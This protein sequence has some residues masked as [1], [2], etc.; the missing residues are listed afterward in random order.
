MREVHG[1][2]TRIPESYVNLTEGVS[3][4]TLNPSVY[5]E[6][7]GF[8]MKMK[9]I[10]AVVLSIL[11]VLG[12][13][14][15][16]GGVQAAGN[17]VTVKASQIKSCK[18]YKTVKNSNPRLEIN[19]DV[20]LI[21]DM[22]ADLTLSKIGK[23]N[24]TVSANISVT[25]K[26]SK[27]L[28]V[29]SIGLES[30]KKYGGYG[31][32]NLESGSNVYA[33]TSAP[34]GRIGADEINIKSGANFT[35]S[36]TYDGSYPDTEPYPIECNSF[37]SSGNL[38]LKVLRANYCIGANEIVI[39]GGTVTSEVYGSTFSSNKITINSGY[40]DLKDTGSSTYARS[41]I[42]ASD[43][44]LGSSLYIKEPEGAIWKA[45][46]YR[47]GVH[48]K[49]GNIA[50]H[51]I[52][53]K[54]PAGYDNG[55]SSG[56]GS[57]TGSNGG[58][59]NEWVNG[60]WYNA[61]GSQT[62]KGTLKWKSDATGWWVED[63]DGWYPTNAWQK[64]DGIWYFFK[65]D[66][67]MAAN[68]YYNGYW[69]NADGSWAEQYFLTWKQNATGWWVEDISG[70]WPSN[71]WLKI[72]GYWYYFDASGYMVTNQYVDGWWIGADGICY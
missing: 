23:K 58:Y 34:G 63:T 44:V 24:W 8:A 50:Y 10:I 16:K 19:E 55:G 20:N 1:K 60:K 68:E 22:D 28:T 29:D 17:T 4:A 72:D 14:S 64:I 41:P 56:N 36:N 6:K 31:V 69:F 40:L 49:N 66:G 33:G 38:N 52:I 62:Y 7:E 12:T 61:D 18:Y 13:I 32:L 27:K 47:L 43:L 21:I 25:I 3:S 42:N 51:V 26:G 54:K 48:D 35:F 15:I 45:T 39:N 30:T 65:P 70:W 2:K 37:T 67:Y 71:S 53:D 46:Y 57:G 9:R 5:K 59:S 11:M